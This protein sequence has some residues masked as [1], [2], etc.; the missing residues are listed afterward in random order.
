MSSAEPQI[1][2]DLITAGR[3]P[4]RIMM[5]TTSLVVG[6]AENQVFLL[7]RRF[8][9]LGHS[10]DVVSMTEPEAYE[11]E[12]LDA[13]VT[14]TH[15]GFMRGRLSL[16]GIMRFVRRVREWR[17]DVV[18]S[19]MVH[20]N[21]LARIGRL[22]APVRVSISTVHSLTEGSR[23]REL[24]YRA[25]DALATLTTNV[26]VVGA[27]RYQRVGAVPEGRIIPMPNGIEVDAFAVSADQR[28]RTREQLG[29]GDEFVW[30][31]VGRLEAPKDM[32]TMLRAYAQL[33]SRR[34]VLLIVGDGPLKDE[35]ERL[36]QALGIGSEHL[37][38]LGLRNDVPDLL[39]AA[40][41][42]VM[43]SAWEGL[44]LVLIE[45][46]SA[47]LPVVATDVGGNSEVVLDGVN[48]LLVP[49]GDPPALASAM[50]RME[51]LDYL[52]RAAMG[53]AGLRLAKDKYEIGEVAARWLKLY[54]D[55]GADA[56]GV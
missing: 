42:Y 26:C 53:A 34:R 30:L 28:R 9:K 11:R 52:E 33:P 13:G 21:L 41:S 6:G 2:A 24:A 31:A 40:D 17:P 29:L 5:V 4:L 32:P 10:V 37:R 43:S 1:A 46:S 54:R 22:F 47:S 50:V 7:A 12:L 35:V 23:W 14:V 56:S 39:S 27:E 19:H 48:G 16:G 36:A 25:T 8:A 51:N 15:L 38:F 55:L 18:H 49:A 3:R 45:A 44:P 20:A